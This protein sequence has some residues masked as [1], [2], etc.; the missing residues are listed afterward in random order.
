MFFKEKMKSLILKQLA[1]ED[2]DGEAIHIAE[3]KVTQM[4]S[5]LK[6]DT[7]NLNYV[8]VKKDQFLLEIKKFL[9]NYCTTGRLYPNYQRN[10]VHREREDLLLN[11]KPS[12][13]ED[14]Y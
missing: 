1:I 5:G 11:S 13:T 7:R 9:Y 14:N 4:Y 3:D 6:I 8:P 2:P 12:S 10:Q